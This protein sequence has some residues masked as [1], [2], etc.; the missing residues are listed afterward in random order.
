VK[1]DCVRRERSAAACCRVVSADKKEKIQVQCRS[2][3]IANNIL[4]ALFITLRLFL[5][6]FT[7]WPDFL[8]LKFLR[9]FFGRFLMDVGRGFELRIDDDY[10]LSDLHLE[11]W[12]CLWVRR[13]SAATILPRLINKLREL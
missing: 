6:Y 8:G 4:I 7:G 13:K 12:F 3:L 11:F 10:D 2:V 1:L 9:D 5:D